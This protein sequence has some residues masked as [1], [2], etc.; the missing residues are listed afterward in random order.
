MI[1]LEVEDTGIGM[2][3]DIRARCTEPFFSTKGSNGWLS[4][5][6][7]PHSVSLM[8]QCCL[9]LVLLPRLEAEDVT[10]EGNPRPPPTLVSTELPRFQD[11]ATVI[12]STDL[13]NDH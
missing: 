3:E 6:R 8:P 2:P 7:A 12:T 9:R 1:R 5:R 10:D 11:R 13:W 4:G